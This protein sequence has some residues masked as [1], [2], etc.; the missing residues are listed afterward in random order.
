MNIEIVAVLNKESYKDLE[1]NRRV[2]SIYGLAPTV[3][4]GG[5]THTPKILVGD[6]KK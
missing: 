2:Y 1:Q 5:N 6:V 4:A 3:T